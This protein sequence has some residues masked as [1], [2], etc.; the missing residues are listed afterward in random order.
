[1]GEPLS[2]FQALFAGHYAVDREL[3]YGG[4]ATV[5][6]ATDLQHRRP[7][8]LKVMHPELAESL[9][10]ERFR[11][12]ITVTTKLHHPQILGVYDSGE[13]AG[14]FWYAMPYVEGES[15]RVTLERERRL[16]V[17]DA[18]RIAR[19]VALALDYAHE[20]GVVHRDVKPENVLLE[21]HGRVLLADFGLARATELTDPFG[22]AP[23]LTGTGFVVGTPSYMSPEQAIGGEL[24][25]RTDIYAL[26]C[27][28]YEMLTG[29][30]PFFGPNPQEIIA[31]R[32]A[33]PAPPVSSLREGVPPP[34][35]AAVDRALVRWP[36]GRFASAADFARALESAAV[37]SEFAAAPAPTVPNGGSATEPGG[38]VAAAL[39][40]V[41]RLWRAEARRG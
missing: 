15:L 6:L 3:G 40:A 19:E 22:I 37:D 39:G 34:V 24:D 33:L 12:E 7:V 5:L 21:R 1:M 8:A 23:A 10:A 13:I 11:R 18:A 38:L 9:G 26:G 4:M 29:E 32:V 30:T 41:R 14:R 31:R 16:P 36:G 20:R 25:A 27:V 28:L 35:E 2:T 17:A